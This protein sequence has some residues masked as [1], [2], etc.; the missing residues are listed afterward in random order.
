MESN[1]IRYTDLPHTSKLFADLV[2]N[3]ERVRPYYPHIGDP[4]IYETIAGEIRFPAEKRAALVAALRQQNGDSESLELLSRE[5][6]VAVVTG[7]QVGLFSGPAYTIYKALT[8]VKLTCDLAARGIAAVPIFWLATEDHDFGEVNHTWV[9]DREHRPLQLQLEGSPPSSQPV[10]QFVLAAP[11]TA[12]LRRALAGLPFA[13]EVSALVEDAYQP[14]TTL[15]DGF[16]RLL[17]RLLAKYG[18]L[19]VDPISPA[20][21]ELAAPAIRTALDQ[22]PE[23]TAA[24][25]ERSRE[26][27]AAGYHAQVH[28]ED[29]TSLVFLLENGRRLT[30]RRH[31]RDYQLNGR[32]FTTEE[33]MERAAEL[34]PNALLRPV[35]QDS[36]LPTL[37]YIGGPAE[38]AYLAQSEVIYRAILGRMPAALPRAGFTLLDQRARKLMAHYRLTLMDCERGEEFVRERMAARLIPPT[39]GETLARTKKTVEEAADRLGHDLAA[40]DTSLAAALEKSRKKMVYQIAKIERK[41]GREIMARDARGVRDAAYLSNLV[42]PQRHLQER[43]YSILP[44]L[45]E[46]GIGLIDEL[47][48]SL[49]LGCPDHQLAVV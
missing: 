40:F 12:E 3:P 31:G 23:L 21:R 44:F 20:V 18:L 10:G 6:T 29:H 26:L 36:M 15:G 28:V 49:S 47:Y 4:N 8:A 7:Q 34:S 1:C 45:A 48:S 32:R 30:L 35:V 19:H 25:R 41:I 14:G 27:I 5:G 24:V 13:D 37:A 9:F 2:Y 46:H 38:L 42:Y 16:S 17:K 43:L 33:L 39:L 11:P 22:A